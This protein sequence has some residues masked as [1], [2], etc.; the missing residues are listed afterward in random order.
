VQQQYGVKLK[1]DDPDNEAIFSSMQS[2]ADHIG[3]AL[4]TQR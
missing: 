3:R 2:L 4:S 1:A